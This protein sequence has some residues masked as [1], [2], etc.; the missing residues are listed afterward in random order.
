MKIP[1]ELTE[2]IE[3]TLQGYVSNPEPHLVKFDPPLNMRKLAAQLNVLPIVLDMGGALVLRT[4]GEIFSFT[5]DEPYRLQSEDDV[6]VRNLVYFQAARKFP[7]LQP[8]VP[9]RP[10]DAY[11]CD[12]CN[13][14]GT[15]AGLPA[16]LVNAVTC[17]CGGIGWLT[18]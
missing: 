18:K 15:V 2:V 14:T 1:P 10:V 13:G 5:W 11:D 7:A 6:R 16:E 9:R 12:Y 8:L 3:A 4:D 17:Y